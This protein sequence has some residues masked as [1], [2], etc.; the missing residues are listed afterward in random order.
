LGARGFDPFAVCVEAHVEARGA[1]DHVGG[2]KRAAFGGLEEAFEDA[3]DLAFAALEQ[4][5]VV[6]VAIDG[7]A[8]GDVVGLGNLLGVAPADEIG[9]D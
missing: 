7:D 4:A 5:G 1:N 9:F 3:R 2:F 8:I 6:S